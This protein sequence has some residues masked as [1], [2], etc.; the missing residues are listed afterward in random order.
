MNAGLISGNILAYALQ[1]GLVV[2]LGAL[3]PPVLRMRSPRARLLYW[4]VLLVACLALPWVR[5]W[6]QEVVVSTIQVSTLITAS[7]AT[8]APSHFSISFPLVA[9][10]LLA[11][12]ILIRLGLMAMGMT[13]LAVYRRRSQELPAEFR[14]PESIATAELLLSDDVAS[15][16]TFG[17][18]N[19]VI[20]LPADFTSLEGEMR[21]AILCHEL[22]HVDR[23][24]WVFTIAEEL[25]RAVL[26]FHPAV[27]WVI[28]EIHLS[29][30]QTVDQ[31]A[32]EMTQARG[33]YVD[34]LLLMAGTALPGVSAQMDLAPAPMFLRRRHLKR[35][36]M[37]VVKG[38]S[39]K[40]ISA[41]RLAC[42]MS[43]AIVIL[44][45]ACWLATGAFPLAAAPQVAY[46]SPGVA[47]SAGGSQL[48]HRA[49]VVYPIEAI[50]KG[51][52]GSVV[53]QVKLDSNG[54]VSD[55]QV[56][57][58]P[59]ELRK[60]V[61]QS[62]LNWH[63]DKSAGSGVRTVSVD[64][65]KPVPV[66][67]SSAP[68]LPVSKIIG[69]LHSMAPPPPVAPA[70]LAHI[71]VGGLPDFAKAE[72]LA[73]L[74]V[75]EGDTWNSQAMQAVRTAVSQFDSHLVVQMSRSA[76]GEASLS[77]G[78]PNPVIA[79]SANGTRAVLPANEML[80]GLQQPQ[81]TSP[82]ALPQGVYSVG[83]GTSPPTIISKVDPQYS[84][85]ARA[86]KYG[87]TVMLA[88]VVN[89]E[90]KAEDIKVVK[91]LGMGLDEK[92]VEAL[93][94][95]VFRPGM[96]QGVPVKVRAQIEVNFRLD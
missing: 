21:D 61:L 96:N 32:I 3:V 1:I 33:S 38:A 95:W 2:G 60:T 11:A 37:E 24:D 90:G 58:G 66:S 22:L 68:N 12:G 42:I 4:Q 50:A 44:S 70:R 36:L 8:T 20:L 87:G 41:P 59:D 14:I 34:T 25:V 85:E 88:V 57:S 53:V 84:E 48:L 31:L 13:R 10:W 52:E 79:D 83:N 26:W 39:V 18:R 93:Q 35:R 5:A 82:P 89:P 65:V 16:V 81:Y 56:L 91:S 67:N 28:G 9:L 64:F 23:R 29:R 62:V 75:H 40:K 19:P 30:E 49:P 76:D 92:A 7:P 15:P 78:L 69:G 17:W 43:A 45:A 55:A 94:Q 46:D 77:I 73:A 74:P 63:F 47:V 71:F 72:L 80:G 6:R 86:A 27:W 51:V 54:E